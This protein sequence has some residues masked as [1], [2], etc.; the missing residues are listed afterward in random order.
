M[1]LPEA[2]LVLDL[3]RDLWPFEGRGVRVPKMGVHLSQPGQEM[4]LPQ[5]CATAS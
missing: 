2:S 3:V 5:Y 1:V 4:R